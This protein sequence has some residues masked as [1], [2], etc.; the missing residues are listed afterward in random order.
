LPKI[1]TIFSV[2]CLFSANV[3]AKFPFCLSLKIYNLSPK[4][5]PTPTGM[6]QV[7]FTPQ[8]GIPCY[9]FKPYALG[10]GLTA[11]RRILSDLHRAANFAPYLYPFLDSRRG[12]RI[13]NA[14]ST[15]SGPKEKPQIL[16]WARPVGMGNLGIS[17]HNE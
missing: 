17:P 12:G 13:A 5:P 8:K 11:S 6:E 10:L 1:L 14:I 4:L 9:G 2:I 3:T 15:V 7:G 16:W